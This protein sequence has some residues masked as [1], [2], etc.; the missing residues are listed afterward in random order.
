MYSQVKKHLH[1]QQKS[2]IFGIW[3]KQQSDREL[4]QHIT[5]DHIKLKIMQVSMLYKSTM[6]IYIYIGIG[7]SFIST[8][9]VQLSSIRLDWTRRLR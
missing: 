8:P 7:I 3:T 5:Y 6:S 1:E 4:A 9:S 2:N